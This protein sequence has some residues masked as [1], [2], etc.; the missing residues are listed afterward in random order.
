MCVSHLRKQEASSFTEDTVLAHAQVPATHTVTPD[1]LIQPLL[2]RQV[3]RAGALELKSYLWAP[4]T[5][6]SWGVVE[7]AWVRHLEWLLDL[8]E[9]SMS[10]GC[11]CGC[12]DCYSHFIDEETEAKRG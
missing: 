3:L 6:P 2:Q 11:Y 9:G 1:S 7:M 5:G 12:G 4:F 10:T 8:G